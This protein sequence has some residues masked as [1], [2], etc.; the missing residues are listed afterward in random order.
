MAHPECRRGGAPPRR[1]SGIGLERRR[2]VTPPRRPR[3]Q[4]AR[5]R[6]PRP[7]WLKF[8]DQFK[9]VLILIL[10]GAAVPGRCSSA[11]SR[12]RSVIAHRRSAQRRARL[13]PGAPCRSSVWRR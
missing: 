2:G 10:I 7:A 9:S 4:P 13:L 5:R 8:A 1:R 3:T 6:P 11:T 12:T